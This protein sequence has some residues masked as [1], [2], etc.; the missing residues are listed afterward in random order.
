MIDW[1][2]RF[3]LSVFNAVFQLHSPIL[4]FFMKIVT[5]LGDA[6]LFWILLAV[7]LLLFRRT[8]KFGVFVLG[9]LLIEV[10]CNELI[11]K[12]IFE[13]PR[14]FNYVPWQESGAYVF[15]EIIARPDSFSFPSGH[16]A[17]SFAAATVL[18]CTNKKWGIPAL[19]L[20]AL[21]GFSRIYCGV[22][23]CTDVLGGM[24]VGVVIGVAAYFAIRALFKLLKR[25]KPEVCE[26]YFLGL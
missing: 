6:G 7:V 9:A 13:R 23:Y 5:Q 20:A 25:K 19:V 17:S 2:Y 12:A 26:K 22:H 21:I 1:I 16:T 24:A 15:P 10:L 18:F 8:R 3:D 14:P 4:N 11:F